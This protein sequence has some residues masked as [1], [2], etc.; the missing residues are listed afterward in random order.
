MTNVSWRDYSIIDGLEA[1]DQSGNTRHRNDFSVGGGKVGEKQ[2]RQSN[3]EYN[4]MQ[5]VFSKKV[6]TV[7]NGV[8]GKAPGSWGIFENFLVLKVTLQSVVTFNL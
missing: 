6:Y 1:K 5:Y 8:W 2:S 3:S 7:Y 4:F